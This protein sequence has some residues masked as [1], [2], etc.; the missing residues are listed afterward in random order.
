MPIYM[1]VEGVDG[2]VT[3]AGFD[4]VI[5]ASLNPFGKP[6]DI[7]LEGRNSP[8]GDESTIYVLMGTPLSTDANSQPYGGHYAGGISVAV[9]DID[10]FKSDFVFGSFDIV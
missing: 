7:L 1:K 3:A 8:A 5:E 10:A 9:G 2:D 4:R 6:V